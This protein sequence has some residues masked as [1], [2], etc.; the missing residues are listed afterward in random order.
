MIYTVTWSP[1]IDYIM[2]V[3]AVALGTTNRA[4]TQ[5]FVIG[6]KGINVSRVL[7]ELETPTTIVTYLGGFTGEYILN[8]IQ[9]SDIPYHAMKTEVPTRINVKVKSDHL[10]TEINGSGMLRPEDF[11]GVYD[12]FSETLNKGDVVVLAGT[13]PST[14]TREKY[15]ALFKLIQTKESE[16]V[17]DTSSKMLLE[18]LQYNPV[19][20]KPNIA[21]LAEIFDQEHI[22]ASEIECYI[23]KLHERGAQNVLL[24]MGKDGAKLF[25][26]GEGIY[27]SMIAPGKVRGTVGAGDS[28]VAGFIA[29]YLK[30][31][32]MATC[33][34]TATAAGCATAYSENLATREEIKRCFMHINIQ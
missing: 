14:I 4:T 28:M 26:K 24:S 7:Q 31:E 30:K 23:K 3:D 8:E 16:C 33:L 13:F 9:T 22:E 11:A 27:T 6:G 5:R 12:Y 20:I 29:S 1:S 21:E 18:F 17:I 34:K 19:L 32:D 15:H 10:E 2:E 25:T